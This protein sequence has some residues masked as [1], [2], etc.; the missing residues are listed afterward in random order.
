MFCWGAQGEEVRPRIVI[1]RQPGPGG[2]A[3]IKLRRTATLLDPDNNA[4]QDLSRKLSLDPR[5]AEAAADIAFGSKRSSTS[6]ENPR[7]VPARSA[8]PPGIAAETEGVGTDAATEQTLE[9]TLAAKSEVPIQQKAG[10]PAAS[11]GCTC[12]F[13]ERRFH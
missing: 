12:K 2:V 10:L 5:I 9:Q 1:H 6:E 8:S 7:G 11:I 13:A 4:N 3:W